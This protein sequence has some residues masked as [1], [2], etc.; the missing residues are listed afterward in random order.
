MAEELGEKTEEP[1]ERRLDEARRK[2]QVPKSTDLT[3][4]VQLVIATLIVLLVGWLSAERFASMIRSMVDPVALGDPI[5]QEGLAPAIRNATWSSL[6]I[7]VPAALLMFV[8]TAIAAGAQV[9]WVWSSD[10]IQPKLSRLNPL[11]GAKRLAKLRNFVRSGIGVCKLVMVLGLAYLVI[12]SRSEDLA[13]LP[14]LGLGQMLLVAGSVLVDLLLWVLALLL[15]LGILDFMY[16]KWQ[17]KKD[18]R[19]SKQEVK[20]ERKNMDGDPEIKARQMKTMQKFA[21]QR[22]GQSVPQA[23]VIVTNPTHFS[24]AIKYEDDWGA[25]RVTAKGADH[26]AFRIR[27][28][29][30]SAGVPIVERPPLARALYWGTE[31]GSAIAPEHY[32]A[33]AEVLAYV[34]RMD[35]RL[36]EDR[37][38]EPAMEGAAV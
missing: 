22:M 25:P 6:E 17:H 10:P 14:M 29:A 35:G 38:P 8:A 28:L 23:D 19:M 2:G 18:L 37:R 3:G 20:D 36:D 9:G 21:M 27:H 11:E 33:V 16:Q 24:V 31:I 26:L 32:E 12:R 15:I 34:Y 5:L 13:M 4:S 1:T 30:T 7:V